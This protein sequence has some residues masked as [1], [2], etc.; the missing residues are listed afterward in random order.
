MRQMRGN[1][2][3]SKLLDSD[4]SNPSLPLPS[5]GFRSPPQEPGKAKSHPQTHI[6]A[7]LRTQV[8]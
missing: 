5:Q 1:L 6:F 3:C 7:L 8:Q 2:R 4:F